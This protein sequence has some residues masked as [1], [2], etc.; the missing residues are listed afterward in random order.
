M[1]TPRPTYPAEFRPQIV[2][3]V[4]AARTPSQLACKLGCTAQSISTCVAHTAADCG[5]P[6]RGKIALSGAQG[7]E[8]VAAPREPTAQDRE[9]HLATMAT[10]PLAVAAP[11]TFPRLNY[12]RIVSAQ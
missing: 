7:D 3:L 12:R 5:K 11:R 10:W 8:L 1:L 2:E 9:G 4:Q 6:A